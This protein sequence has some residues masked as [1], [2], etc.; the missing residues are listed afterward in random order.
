[1][2]KNIVVLLFTLLVI[3]CASG[4][5]DLVKLN[6]LNPGLSRADLAS[7]LDGREPISTD[8][9]DGYYLLKYMMYDSHDIGSRPYYFVFD[10]SNRLVGWEEIK[11]QDKIIIGGITLQI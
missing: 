11:G 9:I 7:H 4:N 10:Q 3:G 5:P 1:M 6:T 8:F 2:K